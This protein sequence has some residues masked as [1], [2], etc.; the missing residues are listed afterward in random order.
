MS[1]RLDRCG[2]ARESVSYDS[3]TCVTLCCA[4]KILLGCGEDNIS[5]H[6]IVNSYTSSA[7]P[8]KFYRLIFFTR[9]W[10]L[11]Q[12]CSSMFKLVSSFPNVVSSR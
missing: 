1:M 8:D 3:E 11:P 9:F 7:V 5:T 12:T 4:Y 6:T 10:S 2:L